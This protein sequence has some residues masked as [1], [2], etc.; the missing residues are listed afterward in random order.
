VA[1]HRET[2]SATTTADAAASCPLLDAV[3]DLSWFHRE[4]Q[5]LYAP[6]PRERRVVLRRHAGPTGRDRRESA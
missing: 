1:P 6:A 4:H 5:G 2:R 3:L